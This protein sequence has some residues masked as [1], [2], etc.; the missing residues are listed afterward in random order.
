MIRACVIGL[1]ASGCAHAAAYR[2][3]ERAQLVAVC[4]SHAA[5][6][7][8]VAARLHVPAFSDPAEM[9]RAVKPDLVSICVEGDPSALVAQALDA[10]CHVLCEA[11]FSADLAA[12]RELVA[13]ARASGR[14]LAADFNL[15][16]TP[17]AIKAREWIE[18]GRLGGPLFINA[19]TWLT[20]DEGSEAPW[21]MR[22]LMCH[23]FDLMR[24]LCGD[25]ERVHT[26]AANAPEGRPPSSM[27]ANMQ[28]A[29]GVVGNL[30]VSSD[31]PARHPLARWEVA[32]TTARVVVDNVY[33]EIIFYPHAEEEKTVITNSIFGGLGGYEETYRWRIRRLLDQVAAGAGFDEIEGSAEDAL[34]AQAVAEAAMESLGTGDVVRV[35]RL[36]DQ[37]GA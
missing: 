5:R 13:L 22:R 16:F 35:V 26:F 31:M 2:G 32:G 33:E 11:P 4:D 36:L 6:A 34:A 7:G 28:F 29:S 25:V 1:G 24:S 23:G 10:D 27:Q 18:A 17:A 14:I 19:A 12:T 30:T 3:D 15:R 21:F 9:L 8:A 20:C 37:A